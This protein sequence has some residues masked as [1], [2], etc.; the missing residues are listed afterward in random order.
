MEIQKPF[1]VSPGTI[2]RHTQ[3]KSQQKVS[4]QSM[5]IKQRLG[6]VLLKILPPPPSSA[7]ITTFLRRNYIKTLT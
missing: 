6:P 2:S 7:S 1:M 5:Y 3:P 4:Y